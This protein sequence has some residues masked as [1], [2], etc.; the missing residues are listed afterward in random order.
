MR[1][2]WLIKLF[3]TALQNVQVNCTVH[4]LLSRFAFRVS[5]LA[6]L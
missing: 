6:W 5:S 3:L 4:P 1:F 2:R